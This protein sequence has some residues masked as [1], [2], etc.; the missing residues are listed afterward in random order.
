M[1]FPFLFPPAAYSWQTEERL[2]KMIC[3]EHHLRW[4]RVHADLCWC[5][6]SS[7]FLA[8]PCA[9]YQV[10]CCSDIW[11]VTWPNQLKIT[12][13]LSFSWVESNSN[14]ILSQKIPDQFFIS[15]KEGLS[16]W[17][18][19]AQVPHGSLLE[20]LYPVFLYLVVVLITIYSI[21]RILQYK[22]N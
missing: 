22:S 17:H 7:W 20:F 5:N 11:R 4:D 9:V 2:S 16:I 12:H 14:I 18:S 8:Y 10:S 21:F 19:G 6:K 3:P 15:F 13:R 1:F